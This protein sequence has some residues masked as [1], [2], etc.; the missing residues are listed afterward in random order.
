MNVFEFLTEI[1]KRKKQ[2]SLLVRAGCG[3]NRLEKS[4]K[5]VYYNKYDVGSK[6]ILTPLKYKRHGQKSGLLLKK[7]IWET[8]PQV[9]PQVAPVTEEKILE[10]CSVPRYRAE[11]LEYLKLSD[12][13]IS[14]QNNLNPLLAS[15]KLKMT[16]PDKP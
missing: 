9:T 13:K 6:Y 16:I 7:G 14:E 1:Q 15:G 3:C 4:S 11:L 8:P 10:F 2:R 12:R 5:K